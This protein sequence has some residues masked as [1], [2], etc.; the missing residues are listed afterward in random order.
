MDEPTE[1]RLDDQRLVS[2]RVIL[3]GLG[4]RLVD[5]NQAEPFVLAEDVPTISDRFLDRGHRLEFGTIVLGMG[6]GLDLQNHL[7]RRHRPGEVPSSVCNP[8]FA[9]LASEVVPA[10]CCPRSSIEKSEAL[11]CLEEAVEMAF[12]RDS[13]SHPIPVSTRIFVA[14]GEIVEAVIEPP[15]DECSEEAGRSIAA[16][17]IGVGNLV[18]IRHDDSIERFGVVECS[19]YGITLVVFVIP[20]ISDVRREIVDHDVSDSIGES[21]KA[22]TIKQ[23]WFGSPGVGPSRLD[24][25]EDVDHFGQRLEAKVEH[26]VFIEIGEAIEDSWHGLL[27]AVRVRRRIRVRRWRSKLIGIRFSSVAGERPTSPL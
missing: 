19:E 11:R 23:K 24:H 4:K 14:H 25:H 20:G 22:I 12:G 5:G 7:L 10:G 13:T 3:E 26:G 6:I 2:L 1:S 18:E 21:G 17:G 16:N 27:S 15:L 8:L 9:Q